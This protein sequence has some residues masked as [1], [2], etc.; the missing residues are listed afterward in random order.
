MEISQQIIEQQ[1]RTMIPP[2]QGTPRDM[3][4]TYCTVK[5]GL[6]DLL[7]YIAIAVALI[8]PMIIGP[9]LVAIFQVSNTIYCQVH[10]K[11]KC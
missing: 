5:T 7:D 10:A 11:L 1:M 6:N 4:L 9:F 3:D 2:S 8:L